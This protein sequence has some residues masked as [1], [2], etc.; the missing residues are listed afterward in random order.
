MRRIDALYM[1]FSSRAVDAARLLATK[2]AKVGR[3][4]V[5]ALIMKMAIEAIYRRPN[6]SDLAPEYKIYLYLPCNRAVT[7]SDQCGRPTAPASERHA[8]LST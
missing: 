8:T 6:I 5:S 2:G 4:H 1:D 3:L 7:R